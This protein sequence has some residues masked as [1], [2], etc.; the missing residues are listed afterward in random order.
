MVH[1]N[2]NY[3]ARN[4]TPKK[5]LP[6]GPHAIVSCPFNSLARLLQQWPMVI[7]NNLLMRKLFHITSFI[8]RSQNDLISISYDAIF[9][10]TNL[11]HVI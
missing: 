6:K 8:I 1:G 11:E 7:K 3:I 9:V 2:K 10:T 5:E 4:C